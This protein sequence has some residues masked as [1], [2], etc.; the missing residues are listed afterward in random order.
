[1][2]ETENFSKSQIVT[3]KHIQ[4]KGFA[5]FLRVDEKPKSP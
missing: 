4:K 3:L 1:M 2:A 5:A